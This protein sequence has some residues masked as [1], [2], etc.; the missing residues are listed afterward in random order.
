MNDFS[1]KSDEKIE[2]FFEENEKNN[3]EIEKPFKN[4]SLFNRTFEISLTYE[5]YQVIK[6]NLPKGFSLKEK[7]KKKKMSFS[8]ALPTKKPHNDSK[9]T[10]TRASYP[11]KPVIYNENPYNNHDVSIMNEHINDE[12]YRKLLSSL[13]HFKTSNETMRKCYKILLI[14]KIHP[15]A[16]PF[17]HPVDYI[18][19]KLPDY[20]L[21]IKEPMDLGTIER[22]LLEG[23]YKEQADFVKDV[24]KVWENSLV[25]NPKITKI[26]GIT[27][28]MKDYF[29]RLL[30]GSQAN[31]KEN[32][33]VD[34]KIEKFL[35][36]IENFYQKSNLF[37][38]LE[39]KA[40][41]MKNFTI[42]LTNPEKLQI[43][44]K[45]LEIG[46]IQLAG[47]LELFGDLQRSNSLDISS[48]ETD[49]L[50]VLLCYLD[51]I[52]KVRIQRDSDKLKRKQKKKGNNNIS[53]NNLEIEEKMKKND[54][55]STNSSFITNSDISDE[56]N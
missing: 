9:S 28:G 10:F 45:V 22:K 41:K 4:I 15:K 11:P 44:Q 52:E 20:P 14:L 51:Y 39:Q 56:E 17:L 29:E 33:N 38:N 43:K 19:L 54:F 1:V 31:H 36:N 46:K 53:T 16:G 25:Y 47:V 2:I 6:M 42:P 40:R 5:Q 55:S 30:I 35:T 48:L 8:T 32:F 18:S 50:R 21:I 7:K 26:H 23:V 27:L 3:I 34:H 24:E 13:K 12:E 49:R 37:S